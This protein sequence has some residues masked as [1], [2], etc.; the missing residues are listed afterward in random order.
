MD[1]RNPILLKRPICGLNATMKQLDVVLSPPAFVLDPRMTLTNVTFDPDPCDLWSWYLS[2][3]NNVHH[4]TKFE[5]PKSN[6]S[7]DMNFYLRLFIWWIIFYSQ[8]DDQTDRQKAMHKSPLC[9]STGGLK[10]SLGT[11]SCSFG[12]PLKSGLAIVAVVCSYKVD[13]LLMN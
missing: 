6:G 10:N 8:T 1:R 9:M 4:H 2:D 12:G 3:I 7:R 13:S 5:Q 11:I